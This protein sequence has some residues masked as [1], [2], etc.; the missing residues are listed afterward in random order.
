M[1]NI[2]MACVVMA[3]IVMACIV[4]ANIVMADAETLHCN[5]YVLRPAVN[6]AV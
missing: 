2:V 3:N 4:M 6:T 1:T 5:V